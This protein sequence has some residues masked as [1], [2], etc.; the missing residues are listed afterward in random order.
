[1]KCKNQFSG[2]RENK[3]V[4]CENNGGDIGQGMIEVS[5]PNGSLRKMMFTI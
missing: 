1:M 5:H 4:S 3:D 2:L